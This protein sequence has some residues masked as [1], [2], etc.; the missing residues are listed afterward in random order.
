MIVRRLSLSDYDKGFMDV[1]SVFCKD[2]LRMT[3][4]E[5]ALQYEKVARQ[6][7]ITFVMEIDGRIVATAKVL[8]EHKFH[9]PLM[10]HIED[11]AVLPEFRGLGLGKK[12]VEHAIQSCWDQ[13]CYKVTLACRDDLESFYSKNGLA[14]RGISM[15]AYKTTT[16]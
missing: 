3:F 11:V 2:D 6:S 8:Y 12:V 13:G 10:G 16:Q 14:K 1:V 15:N 7:G 9:H 5:F 4:E